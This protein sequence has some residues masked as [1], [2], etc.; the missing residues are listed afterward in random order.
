MSYI[1]T[2][3]ILFKNLREYVSKKSIFF[4]NLINCILCTGVWIGFLLSL[5]YSPSFLIFTNIKIISIFLDG[6]LGGIT[7]YILCLVV[8]LMKKSE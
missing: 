7:S 5:I 8:C 3:S 4:G 6:M 2:H 1:I